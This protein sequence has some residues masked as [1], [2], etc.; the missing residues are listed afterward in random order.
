MV[1]I[2]NGS[3]TFVNKVHDN[4]RTHLKNGKT[5]TKIYVNE[6]TGEVMEEEV[7]QHTYLAATKEQFFIGYVSMLAMMYKELSGP[8]IKVYAWL[9]EKYPSD[10]TIAIV[11]GI[12]Q[13]M[14]QVIG[15]KVG[16][17]DNAISGLTAKGM[18]YSTGKA[19]YKM[20]P[21]YAYKG[22][23]ADRNRRLKAVLELECP[24]C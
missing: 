10:T 8:E 9:L 23:T 2:S 18:I 1:E 4:M 20:N 6:A 15:I 7:I 17:I 14:S 13:E 22:P 21:R 12:K 3:C 24:H 11:K 19:I 16:T 5:E